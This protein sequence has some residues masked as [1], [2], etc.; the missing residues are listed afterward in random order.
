MNKDFSEVLTSIFNLDHTFS[1]LIIPL[2]MAATKL[3]ILSISN[4][5]MYAYHI[6]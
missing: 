1:I 3:L 5:S 2:N 6:H 4:C